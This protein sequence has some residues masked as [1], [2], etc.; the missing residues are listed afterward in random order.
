MWK[1]EGC[2]AEYWKAPIERTDEGDFYTCPICRET[3]EEYALCYACCKYE[4]IWANGWLTAEHVCDSCLA[5]DVDMFNSAIDA[6][7][8]GVYD[9]LCAVFGDVRLDAERYQ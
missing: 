7:P 5:R 6:L 8:D 2:G 4:P 9:R 1:C 3:V